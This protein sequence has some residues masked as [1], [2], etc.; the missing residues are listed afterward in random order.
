MSSLGLVADRWRVV[1]NAAGDACVLGSGGH[2]EVFLV[3]DEGRRLKGDGA[4]TAAAA[5]EGDTGVVVGGGGQP[6]LRPKKKK[7]KKKKIPLLTAHAV[8]DSRNI[9][10]VAAKISQQGLLH[11]KRKWQ[12]GMKSK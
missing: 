2:A 9:S 8:N 7:K 11:L 5:E 1:T 12:D 3:E 6:P 4:L 10:K